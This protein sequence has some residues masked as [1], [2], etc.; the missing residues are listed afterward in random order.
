[1]GTAQRV[2]AVVTAA[3]AVVVLAKAARPVIAEAI[4]PTEASVTG[5][6][7]EDRNGNDQQDA[8]ERGV[9]GVSV[10]DGVTTVE[11]DATGRYEFAMD[12]ARRLTDVVF[13]T[14]PAGYGVPTDEWM[15]PRFYRDL[16]QLADGAGA[17]ADFA[18]LPDPGGRSD[19]FTFANVADPHVN[20]DM[21][22]QMRQ[23][24]STSKDVAFVQV[25]GDLT[26]NATDA[27][28]QTYRRGTAASKLPVW[29]AVGNHEYFNQGATDY[30]SRIDNY[31]RYVGPEWYSFDHG[32]RHFLVLENNGAAPFAEQREWVERDLEA[33]AEGKRVV[34]L[35]HMPMNVP[36]GSPSQY[37]EYEDLLEQYETELVLVGHEHSNDVDTSWVKGA[38][39]IQT[40]SSSYT[41]DHSPRGFRYVQMKGP[42]F[43]NPFRMYGVER[44]LTITSPAPGAEVGRDAEVQVS[45]Y[46]TSE[47]VWD[48]SYRVDGRGS[49]RPLKQSG[50]FTWHGDLRTQ[51]GTHEIEVRATD[52]SGTRWSESAGFETTRRQPP[53][54]QPGADWAQFHGDQAHGGVAT[55]VLRPGLRLAWTHRTRGALLTGSPAI[56]DGVAYVG[57]RDENGT[58]ESGVH[59]IDLRTG[60]TRWT[61]RTPSSVHGTP[62][63]LGNTVFVP[64]LRGT[65]FAVNAQTGALRWKREVEPGQPPF[66]QRSYSY[67]S[68]A[69]ANGKVYWPYQARYGKASRGLLTALDATT[70]ETVWESPMSGSTMSD[71]TP[72]IADGRVYVGNE[73]ADRVIAYDAETGRQL[74]T[75]ANRLG[76]WQDGA[77]VAAGGRV[78]IGSNN[79]VIARDATSGADLW[80]HRSPS[81]SYIP[82]NATPS[83]PAVDGG[84]LYMVFPDGRVTA[85][86]A[87]TG[88]VIWSVR[89]PGRAYLGGVLSPPAVSGGTVYVG[90]NDGHLYALDRVTGAEQWRF[91]IGSWVASGPAISGNALLAGAWDGNLYAFTGR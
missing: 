2:L 66:N 22:G 35:M 18:L 47:E 11:T 83:A 33:H 45:A 5:V 17:T 49:W 58:E 54:I 31:R 87:E 28:F 75:A 56:A 60:K 50:D 80:T 63:V 4:D 38:K 53:V 55:D 67:Y 9:K 64:S 16:G 8:G 40:N 20:G 65:L 62:A 19:N 12:V 72:A 24:T 90:S 78:F 39:H 21:Q 29:P 89:L 69:V 85:L 79:A 23:I 46:H 59:A 30:A 34:V 73:T 42:K 76:G 82:N 71:G 44:S 13:I 61:F 57:I 77:P 6:V 81:A 74:W 68:P 14:K 32:K 37:D 52:R 51:A 27:E 43:T 91:E 84:T 3:L 36:F 48:V 7:Y 25:S 41:I 86:S 15:T 26:N 1:M 10:S 70:G 88:A